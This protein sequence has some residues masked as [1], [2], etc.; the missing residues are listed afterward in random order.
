MFSPWSSCISAEPSLTTWKVTETGLPP[1]VL[2]S[3]VPASFLSWS[4]WLAGVSGAANTAQLAMRS[5]TRQ[6]AMRFIGC[7]RPRIVAGGLLYNRVRS[8]SPTNGTT[9]L[10][11]LHW[12]EAHGNG[13]RNCKVKPLFR[14]P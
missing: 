7:L 5:N 11:E 8:G 2:P 4:K 13:R 14:V 10:V 1:A 6:D 3:H 9:C 12:Y